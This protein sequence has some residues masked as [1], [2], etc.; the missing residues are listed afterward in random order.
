MNRRAVGTAYE[1]RA[2][3]YL[4][5]QGYKIVEYNFYCRSGEID[6]IARD[7][8]YLVFVEVK[9]RKNEKNGIPLEAVN[10]KK[11]KVISKVASYYC[12]VHGYGE[13]APCRFDVVAIF[14]DEISL[15]KNAFDYAGY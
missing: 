5:Q 9:Y 7:G 3:E 14:G 12:M 11:Q 1:K 15:V 4:I 6:I 8:E 10:K 13:N 2:G